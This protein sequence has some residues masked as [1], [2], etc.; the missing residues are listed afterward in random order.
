MTI[1]SPEP[2]AP[3]AR[4]R[5]EGIQGNGNTYR[6]GDVIRLPDGFTTYDWT[7]S[8]RKNAQ[9][10]IKSITSTDAGIIFTLTVKA[11]D[12]KIEGTIASTDP[13][14]DLGDNPVL[15][16]NKKPRLVSKPDTTPSLS[17]SMVTIEGISLDENLSYYENEENLLAEIEAIEEERQRLRDEIMELTKMLPVPEQLRM[18]KEVRQEMLA[19]IRKGIDRVVIH[20]GM[21]RYKE[22]ETG[23]MIAEAESKTTPEIGELINIIQPDHDVRGALW[24]L[25]QFEQITGETIYKQ[26]SFTESVPKGM[27]KQEPLRDGEDTI[28]YI[29]VG[30][31]NFS[32][33][34][35]STL[36]ENFLDHHNTDKERPT[37]ATELMFLTLCE[38][39][40]FYEYVQ[41][42]P[43]IRDFVLYMTN[44]DNLTYVDEKVI[45]GTRR[46]FDEGKYINMWPKSLFGMMHG[47]VAKE[48][49]PIEAV[50]K[51]FEEKRN[52][53]KPYSDDEI[54][55]GIPYK[56][57]DGEEAVFDAKKNI[58]QAN[59]D[60]SAAIAGVGRS[61]RAMEILKIS[62]QT[63]EL[64]KIIYH[65][66]P[67]YTNGKGKVE[68]NK[69][70]NNLAFITTKALGYDTYILYNP[71]E[72]RFFINSTKDL[73][74]IYERLKEKYPGTRLI[75]G[76]MIFAPKDSE[77]LK[78]LT[79]NEFLQTVGLNQ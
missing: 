64:G 56:K 63:P 8:E 34:S 24:L 15:L 23:K 75:R 33:Q 41:A 53:W 54:A 25:Q 5:S 45:G 28:L 9:A 44:F 26:G 20:G 22:Y 58:N 27:Q 59:Y 37:S 14:F 46:T 43:W 10:T 40:K 38:E 52:P 4:I 13:F 32:I 29:D 68:T 65:N 39:P 7:D 18:D 78:D 21:T 2:I 74:P 57:A 1:H 79:E 47:S 62:T 35:G 36:K 6:K 17:S 69:I 3:T 66:F 19:T 50:I 12:K 51:A 73:E 16:D 31:E 77:E 48:S 42:N 11:G 72:K 71:T 60:V 61:E 55:S 67:S 30:Q 49:L 76:V 70:Q